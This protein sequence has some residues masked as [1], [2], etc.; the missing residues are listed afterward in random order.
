MLTE[1]LVST[2]P[3]CIVAL[4]IYC[5]CKK[6]LEY[7]AEPFYNN[8][9]DFV[10]DDNTTLGCGN[11]CTC[12]CKTDLSGRCTCKDDCDDC[13]EDDSDNDEVEH[14]SVHDEEKEQYEQ[15]WDDLL[16]S[17]CEQVFGSDMDD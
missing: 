4:I 2:L 15:N 16:S 5:N 12:G 9:E 3:V 11:H 10:F 7:Q 8:T 14:Q 17:P 6:L 13:Q 1:L